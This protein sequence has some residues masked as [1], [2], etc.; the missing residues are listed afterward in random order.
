MAA[1]TVNF[2]SALFRGLFKAYADTNAY[3][4]VL[5]QYQWDLATSYITNNT[6]TACFMGMT[7]AQQVNALNLMTAHLLALNDAINSGQPTGVVTGATIDKV[8]V[9][10][11]PPPESDQWQWWLNQTPYGQQLLALLQISAAGGFFVMAGS[12]VVGT[13]RRVR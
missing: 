8:S 12:P 5:I 4:T 6:N 13:F 2:D 3:P 7:R 10:L 9:T 11:Q 1:I